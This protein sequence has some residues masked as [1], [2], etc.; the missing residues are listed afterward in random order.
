MVGLYVS[1]LP[2]LSWSELG[3]GNTLSFA[4]QSVV[5]KLSMPIGCPVGLSLKRECVGGYPV[6]KSD[7]IVDVKNS[8]PT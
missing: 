8:Y 6:E 3:Y 4:G 2:T 7:Y 1:W 5:N